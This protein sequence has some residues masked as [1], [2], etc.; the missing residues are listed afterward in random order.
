MYSIYQ[1]K[2]LDD[3]CRRLLV[4]EGH[5]REFDRRWCGLVRK[6]HNAGTP[7]KKIH[8]RLLPMAADTRSS[9]IAWDELSRFGGRAPGP[10]GIRYRE[11]KGP[12]VS[13][14]LRSISREI[15]GGSFQLGNSKKLSIRKRRATALVR[16]SC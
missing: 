10:D 1:P 13:D 6:F 7:W 11:P 4:H 15:K 3:H 12:E 9:R 8:L 5:L 14:T 16:S 2:T